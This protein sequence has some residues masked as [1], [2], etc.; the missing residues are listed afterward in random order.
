M[1]DG[2]PI[3]ASLYDTDL[4]AWAEQQAAA[5]RRRDAGHNVL[6]YDNL[7]EEIDDVAGSLLRSC[8]SYL[9]VII[10]HLLKLQFTPSERD[11]A[12]WR[13]SVIAARVNL[14]GDLSPTLRAR[15]PDEMPALF[16]KRLK[17]LR[18]ND[19]SLDVADIRRV[20]PDGYTWEEATG[21]DWW[22]QSAGE[23][24]DQT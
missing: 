9:D 21:E 4:T 7:A 22:P 2:S 19:L 6:D 1:E 20:L 18:E 3:R 15:L 13:R 23:I 12:G 17:L 16:V 11:N 10:L 5:L 14:E 24:E 8:R